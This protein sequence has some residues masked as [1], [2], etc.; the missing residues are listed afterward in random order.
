MS[1][2]LASVIRQ[3]IV[4]TFQSPNQ[5]LSVPYPIVHPTFVS[6]SFHTW[7]FPIA[8]SFPSVTVCHYQWYVIPMV[9]YHSSF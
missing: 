1:H 6:I 5:I 4:V 8:V 2:P 3:S 7:H 9:S